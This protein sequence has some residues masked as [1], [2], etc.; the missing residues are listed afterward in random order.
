MRITPARPLRDIFAHR[1]LLMLGGLLV[2]S[3]AILLW[4]TADDHGASFSR[5]PSAPTS[6][7][8]QPRAVESPPIQRSAQEAVGSPPEIILQPVTDDVPLDDEGL[9]AEDSEQTEVVQAAPPVESYR[10]ASLVPS[11]DSTSIDALTHAIRQ[12]SDREARLA[13]VSSLL[14]I[15]RKS[16][17]DP[18][19]ISAL[20][21]ATKD[22]DSAISA[23]AVSALAEVERATH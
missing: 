8:S 3:Y 20:K 21:V 4:V 13:A 10:S 9:A 7:A 1:E 12:S 5:A 15:G 14:L 17:V 6:V 22:A 2:A 23:Q 19:V 18:A 16:I 11:S